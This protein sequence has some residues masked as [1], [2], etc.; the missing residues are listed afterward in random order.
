MTDAAIRPATTADAAATAAIYNHYVAHSVITFEEEAV[1]APAMAARIAEV[2][3][4][5]LPWLVAEIEGVVVGYSYA[6]RWKAR[7]S[8]PHDCSAS[9]GGPT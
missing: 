3:A 8:S 1:L 6:S 9:A 4:Q 5:N 2:Q 7:N